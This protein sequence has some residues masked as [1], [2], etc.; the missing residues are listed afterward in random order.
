ME[1]GVSCI[2]SSITI[3]PST[4]KNSPTINKRPVT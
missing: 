2:E 3:D 1:K 4:H